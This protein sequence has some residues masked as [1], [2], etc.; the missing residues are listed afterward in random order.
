[1]FLL[2]L[3]GF[4][5]ATAQAENPVDLKPLDAIV[6]KALAAYNAQ[7]ATA[8]FADYAKSMQAIT[9]EQTFNALYKGMFVSTC[10]P[11]P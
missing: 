10:A 8:F 4:F 11:L 7:N 3:I 6:D 5:A 9:N 2:C 1:M